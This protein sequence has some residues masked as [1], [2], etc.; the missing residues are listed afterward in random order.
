[1]TY[2]MTKLIKKLLEFKNLLLLGLFYTFFI[3][4]VFLLPASE[5]PKYR[6]LNDKVIHVLLYIV[7]SFIWLLCFYIYNNKY[8]S[9][10]NLTII[11]FLCFVYGIIIESIQ[12]L[13]I[14]SRYADILDILANSIGSILGALIFWNVKNR[15]KT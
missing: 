6:F 4:A 9:L 3:T 5:I 7:L 12:Q 10:K 13:F 2:L 14:T 1:M 11:I 8:V 15:I